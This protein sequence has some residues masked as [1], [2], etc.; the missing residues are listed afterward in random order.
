M[1]LK[2]DIKCLLVDLHLPLYLNDLRYIAHLDIMYFVIV[3]E[4]TKYNEGLLYNKKLK[5]TLYFLEWI[6]NQ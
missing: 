2:S 1:H 5:G 3:S 6:Q 4:H